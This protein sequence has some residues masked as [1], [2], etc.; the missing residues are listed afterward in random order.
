MIAIISIFIYACVEESR[1]PRWQYSD[2]YSTA[3][4]YAPESWNCQIKPFFS[5]LS[6]VCNSAVSLAIESHLSIGAEIYYSELADGSLCQ[7][8]H[9]LLFS[10]SS[11][12]SL[13]HRSNRDEQLKATIS[14][15]T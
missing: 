5:E 1:S 7:F 6:S 12:C 9:V 3:G 11:T 14:L 15:E 8:W 10:H 4:K 13:I 2:T